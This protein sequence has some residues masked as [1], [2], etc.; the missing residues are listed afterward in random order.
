MNAIKGYFVITLWRA[1]LKFITIITLGVVWAVNSDS[2]LAM[3]VFV[4]A[5]IL[6]IIDGCDHGIDNMRMRSRRARAQTPPRKGD[7]VVAP[8]GLSRCW[9]PELCPAVM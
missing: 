4:G 3:G 6:W 7:L 8:V 1:I 9:W 2:R 5:C